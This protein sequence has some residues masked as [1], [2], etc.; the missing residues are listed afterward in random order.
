[1]SGRSSIIALIYT[2]NIIDLVLID[3]QSVGERSIHLMDTANAQKRWTTIYWR[4]NKF[5]NES[6]IVTR[7]VTER[8]SFLKISV[9]DE[10]SIF[11]TS[12]C[13][14]CCCIA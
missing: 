12:D 4:V 5:L 8:V 13:L 14:H 9:I 1:V 7:F 3:Q 10:I 6:H 2:V 11:G